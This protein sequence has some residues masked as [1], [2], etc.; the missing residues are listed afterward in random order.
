[1]GADTYSV[2]VYGAAGALGREVLIALE[3]E[4]LP[5]REVVPVGST[6]ASGM[7]VRWRGRTVGVT[8]AGGVD[9]HELDAAVLAVP[10]A[11]AAALLP[12]LRA[13][14]VLAIDCSGAPG[15]HPLVWPRLGLEALESHPG[16]IAVPC[17]AASTIAPLLAALAPV[18]EIASVEATVLLPAVAAGKAG[19]TALSSQTLALL[20]HRVPD[21]GPFSGVLAFNVMAGSSAADDRSDPAE[22]PVERELRALLP[23]LGAAAIRVSLVQV[24]TFAGCGVQLTVRFRDEAGPRLADVAAAIGA[25]DELVLTAGQL[26]LRDSIELPEVLVGLLREDPDGAIRCFLAADVLSRVG[27]AVGRTLATVIAQDLW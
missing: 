23:G 10:A 2:A 7:D 14:D 22:A 21:P 3:G 11:A 9:V 19:E 16:A 27:D 12:S 18:A 17:G 15:D 5:I 13:A 1:M 4:A 24:A 25:A 26:A 8:H 20:S 6:L